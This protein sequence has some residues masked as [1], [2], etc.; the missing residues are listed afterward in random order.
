[1]SALGQ[2]QTFRVAKAMSALPPKADIAEDHSHV[3]FVPQADEVRRS[4]TAF[5]D[6]P[7]KGH[8]SAIAS[9]IN[10]REIRVYDNLS[11]RMFLRCREGRSLRRAGRYGLLPLSI[12]PFVVWGTGECFH[13]LE[14]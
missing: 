8:A 10:T 7:G 13:T 9:G 1:M 4:K 2:K 5:D 11:W 6:L 14:A 12:M 3:R